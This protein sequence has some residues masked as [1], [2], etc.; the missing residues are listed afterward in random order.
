DFLIWIHLSSRCWFFHSGC[1]LGL[2]NP[3]GC[4]LAIVPVGGRSAPMRAA[5]ALRIAVAESTHTAVLSKSTKATAESRSCRR[6][7]TFAVPRKELGRDCRPALVAR[8]ELRLPAQAARLCACYIPACERS[9]QTHICQT[10]FLRQ[11]LF[12]SH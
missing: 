8:I 5:E 3:F 9:C 10:A 7:C 1:F 6:P 12:V 2:G 11:F 4:R